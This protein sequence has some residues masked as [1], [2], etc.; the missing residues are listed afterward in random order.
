MRNLDIGGI[1]GVM[2]GQFRYLAG[3]K[4]RPQERQSTPLD[5]C[6]C[7]CMCMLVRMDGG[8]TIISL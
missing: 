3:K 7:M 1:G 6:I 8:S 5:M 4:L 2:I